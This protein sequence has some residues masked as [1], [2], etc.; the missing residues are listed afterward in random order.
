MP[1]EAYTNVVLSSNP[2]PDCRRANGKTMTMPEWKKSEYGIPGSDKRICDG[3]CHCVLV[4]EEL[5]EEFPEIDKKSKLRGDIDTDIGK[6]VDIY[7]NELRLKRLMDKYNRQIGKLPP[8]IYDMPLDKIADY[9]DDLLKKVPPTGGVP[10]AAK[11]LAEAEK[12]GKQYQIKGLTVK[13]KKLT[14]KEW[15]LIKNEVDKIPDRLLARVA[16]NGGSI[17][18][19][20][21]SG[22]TI[23]PDYAYLK[24][25]TPRGWSSGSW[26]NVPGGGGTWQN[27]KTVLVANKL[28][29]GH[30]S[31]NLTLHEHAHTIDST[32]TKGAGRLSDTK[33]WQRIWNANKNKGIIDSPYHVDYA[34]EYF[35]ESF[36]EHFNTPEHGSL[37]KNVNTY[38]KDLAKGFE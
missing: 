34:E 1:P 20:V 37:P 28:K 21:D 19:V 24:G 32:Y 30:G 27:P 13:G 38:F 3:N 31:K 10:G 6:T 26:D 5:M 9:L 22:I 17:D 36:A 7:P 2:C 25:T 29:V 8:E 11:T 4:P 12:W 15:N 23:H 35:A 33:K 14:L 16:K 18:L